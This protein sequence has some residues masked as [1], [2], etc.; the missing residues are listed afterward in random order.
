MEKSEAERSAEAATVAA[1][2]ASVAVF[3]V[4]AIAIII[5]LLVATRRKGCSDGSCFLSKKSVLFAYQSFRRLTVFKVRLVN[6]NAARFV[7]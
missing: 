5:V 4:I 3:F 1:T 2:R 7:W 6:E